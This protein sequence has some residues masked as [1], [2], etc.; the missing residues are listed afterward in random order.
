MPTRSRYFFAASKNAHD[1]FTAIFDFVSPTLAAAWN[2]RWQ[3][4]GFLEVN[5]DASPEVLEKRFVLGSGIHGANLHR[6]CVEDTWEQ[7]QEQMA[8]VILINALAIYDDYTNQI[9]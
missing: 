6:A 8:T 5:G 1:Q 3:V 9:G 2:L 7:Q 4:R